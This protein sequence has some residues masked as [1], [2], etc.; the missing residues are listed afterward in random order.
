MDPATIRPY[1][2]NC[3]QTLFADVN[4]ASQVW[5]T[6]GRSG[7]KSGCKINGPA[8]VGRRVCVLWKDE[9]MHNGTIC[10]Y[11]LPSS[12]DPKTHR[13]TVRWDDTGKEDTHDW[14]DLHDWQLLEDE[15][16]VNILA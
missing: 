14:T 15:L 10:I 6:S 9:K 8:F 16:S 5:E 1:D 4:N 13:H 12:R 11:I 3:F 7:H 2:F